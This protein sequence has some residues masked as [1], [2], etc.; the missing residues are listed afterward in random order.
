MSMP[1]SYVNMPIQVDQL[2]YQVFVKFEKVFE[3][4]MEHQALNWYQDLMYSLEVSFDKFYLPEVFEISC[5]NDD[6]KQM[7]VSIK[8]RQ[9]EKMIELNIKLIVTEFDMRSAI[10]HCT[11]NDDCEVEIK[12]LFMN[13]LRRKGGLKLY[14]G[15]NH[16]NANTIWRVISFI[17][18]IYY[19]NATSEMIKNATS[20]T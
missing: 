6:L 5:D 1:I 3:E 14:H 10:L 2:T 13:S 12:N 7:K 17:C 8:S 18:K 20:G 16:E 9:T 19:P 4:T 15:E 11:I